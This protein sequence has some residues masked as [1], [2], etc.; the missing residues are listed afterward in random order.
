MSELTEIKSKVLKLS[1]VG[2]WV[3]RERLMS[4]TNRPIIATFCFL[5]Q[6]V[7]KYVFLAFR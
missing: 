4:K 1:S 7:F 3:D 6:E 2:T 5:F